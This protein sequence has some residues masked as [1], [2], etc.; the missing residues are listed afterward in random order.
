MGD[1]GMGDEKGGDESD[2]DPASEA[3]NRALS[4][5]APRRVRKDDQECIAVVCGVRGPG[6][7]VVV[8]A[9]RDVVRGGIGM[10][11]PRRVGVLGDAAGAAGASRGGSSDVAVG[12]KDSITRSIADFISSSRESVA[13]VRSCGS[14]GEGIEAR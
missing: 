12:L 6:S 11:W 14:C 9:D 1:V 5:E 2:G 4:V 10:R 3:R 8:F 13:G 7:G